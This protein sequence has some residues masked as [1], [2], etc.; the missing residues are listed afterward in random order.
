MARPELP[1][2][3]DALYR[4]HYQIGN[5]IWKIAVLEHAS[6][7]WYYFWLYRYYGWIELKNILERF[8]VPSRWACEYC[9]ARWDTHKTDCPQLEVYD[10]WQDPM[11]ETPDDDPSLEP[12]LP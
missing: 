3:F 4:P 7:R 12:A 8:L 10:N 9:S 2:L 6:I 1:A 11:Y 5:L